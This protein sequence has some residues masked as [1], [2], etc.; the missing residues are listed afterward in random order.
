MGTIMVESNSK[1]NKRRSSFSKVEDGGMEWSRI[2]RASVGS[3]N[4]NSDVSYVSTT[5]QQ[6]PLQRPVSGVPTQQMQQQQ[7]Q[8]LSSPSTGEKLAHKESIKV[9][10]QTYKIQKK[11]ANKEFSTAIKDKTVII[12]SSWLKIRGSL[13]SWAK[14]WCV[15]K[16]EVLMIYK[17]DSLHHWIGTVLINNCEFIE[18][19]S[20]KEGFCFKILQPYGQSIWTAR[21][22]TYYQHN[23]L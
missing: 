8:Q 1:E 20:S 23:L 11:K 13:K 12:L 22:C 21:V 6:P 2:S 19:P 3:E 4:A 10:K 14:Y 9:R 16:P 7:Q 18:R 5:S 15:V 17:S